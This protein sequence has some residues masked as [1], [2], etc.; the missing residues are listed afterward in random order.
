MNYGAIVLTAGGVGLALG[1]AAAPADE[2]DAELSGEIVG[3]T[4]QAITNDQQSQLDAGK[5]LAAILAKDLHGIPDTT[6]C[7][8]LRAN[9]TQINNYNTGIVNAGTT[10]IRGLPAVLYE[11]SIAL[12][13]LSGVND[14]RGSNNLG[15]RDCFPNDTYIG[16]FLVTSYSTDGK[17]WIDPGP[18]TLTASLGSTQGTS[19]AAVSDGVATTAWKW[20]K[21][22]TYRPAFVGGEPSE[23]KAQVQS[24]GFVTVCNIRKQSAYAASLC[25]TGY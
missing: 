2:S 12:R 21:T 22:M 23:Y 4:Q 24:A 11:V 1:C 15:A 9:I 14:Q 16:A 18:A 6:N 20:P 17:L 19:A 10:T 5:I 25:P 13:Y 3:M 7:T 8:M